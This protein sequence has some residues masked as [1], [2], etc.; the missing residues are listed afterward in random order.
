MFE[1]KERYQEVEQNIDRRKQVIEEG[2][3]RKDMEELEER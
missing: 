2:K 1:A 3:G